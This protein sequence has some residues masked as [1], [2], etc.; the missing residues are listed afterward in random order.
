MQTIRGG[1]Y[2]N[3]ATKISQQSNLIPSQRG[4]IY[5]RTYSVPLV[6][7]TGFFCDRSGSRGTCADEKRESVF[8]QLASLLGTAN[9]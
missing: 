8:S 1:E 3:R 6:L 2:R 7:N 9:R 5:D 4:E